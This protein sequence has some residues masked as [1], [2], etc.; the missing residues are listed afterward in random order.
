MNKDSSIQKAYHRITGQAFDF[1]CQ[2]YRCTQC[3][4][5]RSGVCKDETCFSYFSGVPEPESV[6]IYTL[7]LN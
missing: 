3:A 2:K 6:D 4:A 5:I 1:N 7:C